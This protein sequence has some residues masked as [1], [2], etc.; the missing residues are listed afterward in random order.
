MDDFTTFF[1]LWR[2]KRWPR[3]SMQPFSCLTKNCWLIICSLFLV[4]SY[5]NSQPPSCFSISR[6]S[7]VTVRVAMWGHS[8]N[9]WHFFSKFSE[10]ECNKK[11]AY[12]VKLVYNDH[13]WDP[14]IVAVV[15]G[16]SLFIGTKW[17]P[18][19]GCRYMQVVAIHRWSLA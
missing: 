4:T 3:G 7:S 14:K 11:N 5:V 12:T 13:P 1:C 9:M 19:N 6:K 17:P 18:Q 10:T 2:L 16:W 15:D 8:N